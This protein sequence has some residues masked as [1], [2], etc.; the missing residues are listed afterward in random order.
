MNTVSTFNAFP[1]PQV[2]DMLEKIGQAQFISTLN[3]TKGYWQI[4]MAV[5][6]KESTTFGSP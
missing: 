1:M 4:P 2:E 3:L 5:A 6:D